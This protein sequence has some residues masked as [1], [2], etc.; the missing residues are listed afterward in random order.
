MLVLL[1]V[2]RPPCGAIL[3]VLD[4][5]RERVI[6][7]EDGLVAATVDMRAGGAER[8]YLDAFGVAE[9]SSGS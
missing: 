4:E 7:L 3:S 2:S 1:P 8:A 5:V 9:G 6:L